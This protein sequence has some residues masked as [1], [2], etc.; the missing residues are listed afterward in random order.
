[1]PQAEDTSTESD[2]LFFYL[3]SERT[4]QERLEMGM[5][6]IRSSR[7]LSLHGLKRAFP[8]LTPERFAAK[9]ALAWLQEDCPEHFQPQGDEMTWIQDSTALAAKLHQIFTALGIGYYITG[10]VAAIAYGEPRTTRDLDLVLAIA[11]EAIDPLVTALEAAGFYVPGVDDVRSGR[12]KTLGITQV[13]TISRAD[14]VIAGTD[15]F[16]RMKFERKQD[17]ELPGTGTL[18]FVSAEDLILNKL[19]WGQRSQSEKQWRD[20][21]GVLKVQGTNL[22][23]NYLRNWADRLDLSELLEQALLEAGV[24]G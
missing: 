17:L 22:D 24:P 16:D 3:L 21:L 2:V 1:V 9:V 10:G 20:V 19:R 23:L 13:E 18:Y 7:Q 5:Q 11:P 15:E 6:M 8:D 12:M 4:T 14:L